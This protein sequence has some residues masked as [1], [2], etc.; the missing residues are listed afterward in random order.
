MDAGVAFGAALTAF[1]SGA[2]SVGGV[3]AV[4]SRDGV[5]RPA[6]PGTVVAAATGDSADIL[7]LRPVAWFCAVAFPDAC[8]PAAVCAVEGVTACVRSVNAFA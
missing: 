7:A 8:E 4:V 6:V 5:P 2:L 1:C 3:D